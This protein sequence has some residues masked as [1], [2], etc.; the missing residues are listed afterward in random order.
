MP[1]GK[2]EEL[3]LA[4]AATVAIWFQLANVRPHQLAPTGI[5]NL[6]QRTT[7]S[8][9]IIARAVRCLRAQYGHPVWRW[10]QHDEVAD[11]VLSLPRYGASLLALAWSR[12]R[13]R[14]RASR[15][16]SRLSATLVESAG[17]R[18]P[19]P[20]RDSASWQC[21]HGR[22]FPAERANS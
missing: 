15:S 7:Q 6:A 22:I 20:Q 10:S 18:H 1:R 17:P 9:T 3:R 11:L 19:I 12:S 13:G 2:S 14:F 8:Q 21:S 5:N 4:D 16:S